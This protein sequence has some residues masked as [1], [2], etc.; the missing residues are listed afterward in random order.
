MLVSRQRPPKPERLAGREVIDIVVPNSCAGLMTPHIDV[1]SGAA[2]RLCAPSQTPPGHVCIAHIN[3]VF[4]IA[5]PF[6]PR[7]L[8]YC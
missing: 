4:R 3:T 8:H 1:D 7:R 2:L 5:L 6:V